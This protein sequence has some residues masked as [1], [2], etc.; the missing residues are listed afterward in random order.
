MS[1]VFKYSAFKIVVAKERPGTCLYV[2]SIWLTPHFH[3]LFIVEKS[4]IE[5]DSVELWHSTV[6]LH[7]QKPQNPFAFHMPELMWSI[8][9]SLTELR[10]LQELQKVINGYRLT[11]FLS[12]IP[13]NQTPTY[14]ACWT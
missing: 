8:A 5:H 6:Q 7:A 1:L 9:G 3:M 11:N 10:E 2:Q 12:H 13:G 4:F 14:T